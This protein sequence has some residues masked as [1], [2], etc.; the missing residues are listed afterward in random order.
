M[1][2][3]QSITSQLGEDLG[4]LSRFN[5][6]GRD[7]HFKCMTNLYDRSEQSKTTT[8]LCDE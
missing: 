3:L 5:A 4:L 8:A 1:E 2:A 7:T 6:F